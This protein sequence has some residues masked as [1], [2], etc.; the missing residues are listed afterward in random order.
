[1]G[2]QQLVY[3]SIADQAGLYV[4]YWLINYGSN[5]CPGGWT[6]PSNAPGSCFMNTVSVKGVP[7]ND[8]N[9][10]TPVPITDLQGIQLAMTAGGDD[11][12]HI[13]IEGMAW[14][15]QFP[16]VLGLNQGNSWTFAE[17]GVFGDND[18]DTA[19]FAGTNTSIVVKIAVDSVTPTAA[20]PTCAT[21]PPMG[22]S[23][24]ER[25]DLNFPDAMNCCLASGE[26]ASGDS[27]SI[28]FLESNVPGQ[29]CT[30]CGNEGQVCCN[31]NGGAWC[32]NPASDVCLDQICQPCGGTDEPCCPSTQ[33]VQCANAGDVCQS[34]DFCGPPNSLAA[35]PTSLSIQ[36]NDGY[37]GLNT[38]STEVF[39][40]GY[41][42]NAYPGGTYLNAPPALSASTITGLPAGVT[43]TFTSDE[44]GATALHLTADW[45]E[46]VQPGSY[47]IGATGTANGF[48]VTQPHLVQLTVHACVPLECASN[49]VTCGT[50]DNECGTILECGTC[51]TGKYC[52]DGACE[53]CSGTRVCPTGSY[54]NDTTCTCSKD[55][56]GCGG[57]YPNCKICK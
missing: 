16:S 26:D 37:A 1:V 28:T 57:V 38:A 17:F 33:Y 42:G 6:S 35:S 43:A 44:Y 10:Y 32:A 54:F 11:V 48:T 47:W 4:E 27:P 40:V 49:G 13:T 7:T 22:I 50:L 45:P 20:A 15:A 56:C 8:V 9:A 41:W 12:V 34:N 55:V 21:T 39:A 51:G 46:I 25:N 19:D 3:S 36:N 24:Q 31:A 30:L 53:T 14:S 52:L 18:D 2:A 5:D 23:T 29:S